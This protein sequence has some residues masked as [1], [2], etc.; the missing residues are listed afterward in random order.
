MP[1]SCIIFVTKCI[2]PLDVC[3]H[4]HKCIHSE[5][6][7]LSAFS[8]HPALA[9]LRDRRD[10][11]NSRLPL[12][13]VLLE[14]DDGDDHDGDE[15]HQAGGCQA[16]DERELL[17]DR[18][19]GFGWDVGSGG[20]RGYAEKSTVTYI[21]TRCPRNALWANQ[22]LTRHGFLSDSPSKR[23]RSLGEPVRLPHLLQNYGLR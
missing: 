12:I 11:F 3:A 2:S 23:C 14:A 17:L 15:D 19:L 18:L 13:A 1:R 4:L 20:A 7:S 6:D 21:H 22:F 16:D 5:N 8:L 9:P 10:F